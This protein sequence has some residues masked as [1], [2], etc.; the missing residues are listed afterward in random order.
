MGMFTQTSTGEFTGFPN[1]HDQFQ[2]LGQTSSQLDIGSKRPVLMGPQTANGQNGCTFVHRG[3]LGFFKWRCIMNPM[4]AFQ[5][6]A[7]FNG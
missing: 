5:T 6:H 1:E 3:M 4:Y 2:P 7:W